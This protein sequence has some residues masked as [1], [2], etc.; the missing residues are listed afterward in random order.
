MVKPQWG[1]KRT[2][3]ECSARFYDMKKKPPVCPN[4][5]TKISLDTANKPKRTR[6]NEDLQVKKVSRPEDEYDALSV[7]TDDADSN[8]LIENA[9]ELGED[10]LD[11]ESVVEIEP[12][13]KEDI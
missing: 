12:E 7:D 6:S 3:P 10:D 4:C 5:H 8:N 13:E 9:D 2:C 11:V 1:V